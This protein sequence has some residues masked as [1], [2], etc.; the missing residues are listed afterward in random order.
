[1][2]VVYDPMNAK[3]RTILSEGFYAEFDESNSD[4]SAT[5][6]HNKKRK[7]CKTC[8][9]PMLGH[10]KRYCTKRE[11]EAAA[12]EVAVSFSNKLQFVKNQLG[13][14][15]VTS[16][17]EVVDS[18]LSFGLPKKTSFIVDL[19]M[20]IHFFRESVLFGKNMMSKLNTVMHRAQT[21]PQKDP[22]LHTKKDSKT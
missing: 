16:I 18:I 10:K 14:D 1:M 2:M 8:K 3:K 4:T 11:E 7:M 13:L 12:P 6:C 5:E 19:K 15:S 21:P 22:I 17:P 20:H 9:M